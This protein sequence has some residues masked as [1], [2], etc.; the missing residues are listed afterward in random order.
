[1]S[2][3]ITIGIKVYGQALSYCIVAGALGSA[4]SIGC[5]VAVASLGDELQ[6]R[7][8]SSSAFPLCV[9]VLLLL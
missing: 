5:A 8:R 3:I 7:L 9:T 1:M 6:R 2:T 4:S